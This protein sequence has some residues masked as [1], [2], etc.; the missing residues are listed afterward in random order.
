MKTIEQKAEQYY[1]SLSK[2][3]ADVKG[4]VITAFCC[5]AESEQLHKHDVGRSAFLQLPLH[6]QQYLYTW[7]I[8]HESEYRDK[9]GY[10]D[11]SSLKASVLHE[12][13]SKIST[14]DGA[15]VARVMD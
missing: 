9:Y 4:L 2:P 7:K 1:K 6:V 13:F 15:T 11:L 3:H 14:N 8:T 5:G 12:I 10:L